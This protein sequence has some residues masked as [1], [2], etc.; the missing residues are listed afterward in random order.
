MNSFLKQMV[1]G[2]K[3]G[4]TQKNVKR[5]RAWLMAGEASQTVVKSGL[6]ARKIF[7]VFGG[8]IWALFNMICSPMAMVI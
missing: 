7:S 6:T 1:T 2:E 3:K 8:V 4:L 5:K